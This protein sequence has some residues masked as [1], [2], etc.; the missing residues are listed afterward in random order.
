MVFT[1]LPYNVKISGL[2]CGTDSNSIG[3][4][5]GEF[6]MASGEMSKKEFTDFL[7][8]IVN[9]LILFSINGSIHYLC[10]DWRHI[11]ELTEACEGYTELKNLCIWNKD[12]AGMGTFYRSKHELVFVYKNG[13]EK[14]INNFELGQFGRYRTNVW[15]Y[16]IVNSFAAQERINNKSAGNPETAMH[17]TVKPLKLVVDCIQDCSNI[18]N[19]ILDLFG[20][21]GTTMIASHQTN[22]KG[23]L[24][25]LDPKYCDVIIKR[26]HKLDPSLRIIRNG[27][28]ITDTI[29]NL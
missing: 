8:S 14:H 4:I 26:M 28:D 21:S 24:M 16:P 23:Y 13:K 1:D 11:T 3:N 7:T 22:R 12:N 29:D 20:G 2:G 17:P 10:M 25:E 19:I 18:T 15:D 9:N 27:I 6:V 5:H